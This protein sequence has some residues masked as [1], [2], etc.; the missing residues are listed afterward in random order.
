VAE[1]GLWDNEI[2]MRWYA[3]NDGSIRS[4]GTMYFVL[5]RHGL[6]MSGRWVGLGYDDEIMTGFASMAHSPEESLDTVAVLIHSDGEV[7]RAAE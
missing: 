6:N 7:T 1:L 3:A 4:K 5:H 2:L